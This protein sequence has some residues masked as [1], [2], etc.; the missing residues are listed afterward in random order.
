MSDEE[1]WPQLVAAMKAVTAY[2]R[3]KGVICGVQNHNHGCIPATGGQVIR[4]LDEVGDDYCSHILDTGQF[5]GSPGASG[6]QRGIEAPEWDLYGSIKA[7]APRAVH[8]RAKIYRIA[9]GRE[10][11]LDYDRIMC[12]LDGVGFNGWMSLLYEGQDEL[13]EPAAV[14]MAVAFL[15]RLVAEH[16]G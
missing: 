3:D 10:A 16:G 4:L 15:R 11:W 6:G 13:D 1:A 8:V 12:I 7:T 9:S 14:P 2:G 5:R